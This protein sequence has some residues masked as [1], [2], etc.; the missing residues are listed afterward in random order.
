MDRQSGD[1]MLAVIKLICALNI[2][3]RR[4]KQKGKFGI[5][6]RRKK[7]TGLFTSQGTQTGER[8]SIVFDDGQLVAEK[9]ADTGMREKM[10]QDLRGMLAQHEGL[11]L[12][13]SPPGQGFSTTF[14]AALRSSDR[15]I[16]NWVEVCEAEARDPDVENV[17]VTT[18]DASKGE[19]AM[20]VLPKLLRTYPDVVVIR[21]LADG[22]TA[23][24]MCEQVTEEKRLVLCGIRA[25]DA[26]EALLRVLMLKVPP[27][28]FA[29]VVLGSLN[30]RLVRRLCDDCKQPYAPTPQV[31]QQLGIP[32]GKVQAFFRNHE[33]PLPLPPDAPRNAV[34]QLCHNCGGMGFKGRA[35]VFELLTMTDDLKKVL[36]TTPKLDVLRAAARKSG[37]R[38]M[39]EEGIALVAKGV[40][41]LP[42]LLRVLKE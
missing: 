13:S 15:Y 10:E 37:F 7:L 39:Q 31:L 22:D 34:P 5:E 32:Q 3:E 8:V 24:L 9:L 29:P 19:T 14:N 41:T 6:Y 35:A 26:V 36:A 2:N 17:P 28:E 27:A 12:F 18:Y 40:T 33:G 16:K 42:E 4:A 1:V 30:Q 25:K 21:N 38:T 20:T 23:R 11:I